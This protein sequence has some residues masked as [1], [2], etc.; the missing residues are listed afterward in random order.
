MRRVWRWAAPTDWRILGE[1][2]AEGF[3]LEGAETFY[4]DFPL[5][6]PRLA[7]AGR[8]QLLGFAEGEGNASP[9]LVATASVAERRLH[10]TGAPGARERIGILGGVVV[11]GTHRGH[12]LGREA[13]DRI[14]KHSETAQ[15]LED[16][17][18]WTGDPTL[19]SSYGFL[20]VGEQVRARGV[21]TW[22]N[23]APS[24]TAAEI[25]VV[26][27]FTPA[28]FEALKTT[29]ERGLRVDASERELLGRFENVDW[30]N[31]YSVSSGELVAYL[32]VGRGIDLPNMIH[33]WG[34]DEA[35]LRA[36][37]RECLKVHPDP[38]W[39]FSWEL[40]TEFPYLKR[41]APEF[42]EPLAYWRSTRAAL[43]AEE[44]RA[45]WFWGTDSS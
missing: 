13:I 36:L 27:G 17:L 26:R 43:T 32:G 9:T 14:L 42:A 19:Y 20:P 31:A 40:T 45:L 3:G 25:R 33:E 24:L 6:D 21:P 12:G 16:W 18:L 2:Y 44:E 22:A 29:R 4:A 23:A 8:A 34:G 1:L 38:E 11:R 37:V 35:A 10:T 41:L 30:W 28:L 7:R 5:W 39:I 15:G